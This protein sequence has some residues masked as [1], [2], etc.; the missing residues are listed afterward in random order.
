MNDSDRWL[1]RI[2]HDLR[3]P[4]SPLQTAAWL[5]KG[6]A[7]L[8]PQRRQEL[9]EIVERQSRR[10]TRMIDEL[11]DWSRAQQGR[12]TSLREPCDL[13]TMIDLAI[14]AIPGCTIEPDVRGD[15]STLLVDCDQ[16]RL[17]QALKTLIEYGAARGTT[18]VQVAC[19]DGQARIDVSCDSIPLERDLIPALLSQPDPAPFDEGL[20]LRLPLARAIFEAHGGGIDASVDSAGGLHFACRIGTAPCAAS[21]G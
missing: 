14:S 8:D 2:A 3:G 11:G 19:R 9:L 5:L 18:T 6:E 12:L 17:V 21:D 4:L 10:L 7:G 1:D 13:L 16:Q 15:C 20:G